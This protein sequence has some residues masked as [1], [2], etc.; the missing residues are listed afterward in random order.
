[1][2]SCVPEVRVCTLY[3]VSHGS[4]SESQPK[5][6]R[7]NRNN[8]VGSTGMMS[9]QPKWCQFNRNGVGS[10]ETVS[11]EP[12]RFRLNRN[13]FGCESAESGSQPPA[14]AARPRPNHPGLAHSGDGDAAP[15]EKFEWSKARPSLGL[16]NR[17]APASLDYPPKIPNISSKIKIPQNQ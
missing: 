12:K 8:D 7:F 6:F 1:M 17:T 3:Q 4:P 10:T 14:T 2:T 9:V 15:Q 13:V 11:V 16:P 5:P